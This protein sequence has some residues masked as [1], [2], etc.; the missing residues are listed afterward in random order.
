MCEKQQD[1]H[2]LKILEDSEKIRRTGVIPDTEESNSLAS[3]NNK[4]QGED[5]NGSVDV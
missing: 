2:Q 4:N 3:I 1:F 5:N